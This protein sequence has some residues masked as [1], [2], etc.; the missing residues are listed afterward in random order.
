MDVVAVEFLDSKLPFNYFVKCAIMTAR[1]LDEK[2]RA[3]SV[4][5]E[6][7]VENSVHSEHSFG[8]KYRIS[9]QQ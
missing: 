4:N 3:D 9:I 8:L 7:F 1:L 5:V 2:E 6:Y